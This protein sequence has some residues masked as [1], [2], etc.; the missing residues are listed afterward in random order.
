MPDHEFSKDKSLLA[1]VLLVGGSMAASAI[2]IDSF[3]T[4]PLLS[5]TPANPPYVKPGL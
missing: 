2:V 4:L 1:A 5:G 3:E